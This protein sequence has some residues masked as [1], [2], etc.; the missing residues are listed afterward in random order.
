MSLEDAAVLRVWVL[1]VISSSLTCCFLSVR[2]FEIHYLLAQC[3]HNKLGDFGGEDFW[4][5]GD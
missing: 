4:Y 3:W 5:H 1:D 2:K